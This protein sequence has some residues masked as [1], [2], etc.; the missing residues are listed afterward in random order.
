[1]R[2]VTVNMHGLDQSPAHRV[3][4]LEILEMMQRLLSIE[5]ADVARLRRSK[6]T[7]CPAQV[8]EM[9]LDRS[10]HRMHPDLTWEAVR[11]P[12]VAWAAGRYDVR[13]LV[14]STT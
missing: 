6:T 4:M 1:M 9:R 5:E 13:P 14:R 11:L 7:H 10:V 3:T 12:R 2:V 8:N